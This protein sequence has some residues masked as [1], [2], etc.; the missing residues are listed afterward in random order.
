M[1]E[2]YYIE[3]KSSVAFLANNQ[4]VPCWCR[5]SSFFKFFFYM[6]YFKLHSQMNPHLRARTD[7][8]IT[9]LTKHLSQKMENKRRTVCG[10][11]YK[12]CCILCKN[13]MH[14]IYCVWWAVLSGRPWDC[15]AAVLSVVPL[16]MSTVCEV[17]ICGRLAD[18]P[19]P[20]SSQPACQQHLLLL[21]A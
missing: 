10:L 14:V 15:R 12:K 13:C 20:A 17:W 21:R 2:V 11:E 18:S 7:S 16:Q 6:D 4:N 19:S 1:T 8:N 9:P 3:P 5:C